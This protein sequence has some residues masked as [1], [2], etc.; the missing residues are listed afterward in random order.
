MLGTFMYWHEIDSRQTGACM[1]KLYLWLLSLSDTRLIARP[2][3]ET[4]RSCVLRNC[5]NLLRQSFILPADRMSSSLAARASPLTC[6]QTVPPHNA[7]PAVDDVQKNPKSKRP[8]ERA[9]TPRF[10]PS[11]TLTT[12]KTEMQKRPLEHMASSMTAIRAEFSA[13]NSARRPTSPAPGG[14]TR[15]QP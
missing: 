9:E 1:V 10:K 8:V 6:V 11:P 5:Y 12:S 14:T 3:R 15:G 13:W 2:D 7:I 4:C